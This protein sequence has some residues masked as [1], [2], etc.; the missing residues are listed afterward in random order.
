MKDRVDKSMGIVTRIIEGL[1][2]IKPTESLRL[3]K[4][5]ARKK[6]N[7]SDS[8]GNSP[9]K[10]LVSRCGCKKNSRVFKVLIDVTRSAYVDRQE[11]DGIRSI[12]V[13]LTIIPNLH[14]TCL[15]QATI[16]LRST[17]GGHSVCER[18]ICMLS[19]TSITVTESL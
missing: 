3:V 6:R 12:R 11:D 17:S 18:S 14:F 2:R 9:D 4:R 16:R 1:V 13:Y 10:I 8:S 5:E 15:V 19:G 7:C